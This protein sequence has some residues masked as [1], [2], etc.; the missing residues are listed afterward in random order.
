MSVLKAHTL[1]RGPPT[2]RRVSPINSIYTK[3]ATMFNTARGTSFQ[4]AYSFAQ[5]LSAKF[6]F[7]LEKEILPVLILIK[8]FL[9][10]NS[11]QLKLSGLPGTILGK[12]SCSCS[13]GFNCFPGYQALRSG[14][15]Q[16]ETHAKCTP[17]DTTTTS[18]GSLPGA[19]MPRSPNMHGKVVERRHTKAFFSKISTYIFALLT[20]G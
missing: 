11:A 17:Q 10:L 13:N 12:L 15:C 20:W 6:P 7:R 18:T 3:T 9:P 4:F 14:H 1:L 2:Q 5:T 8:G 19:K 16:F